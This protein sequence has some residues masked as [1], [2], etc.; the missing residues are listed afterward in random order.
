MPDKVDHKGHMTFGPMTARA[1][2]QV[3]P[4]NDVVVENSTTLKWLRL[5]IGDYLCYKGVFLDDS[6]GTKREITVETLPEEPH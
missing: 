4:V 1:T 2:L 6:G 3:D 5:R